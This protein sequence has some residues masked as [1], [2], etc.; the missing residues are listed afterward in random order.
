MKGTSTGKWADIMCCD[1][2]AGQVLGVAAIADEAPDGG[3]RVHTVKSPRGPVAENIA[4][5]VAEA[6]EVLAL[7]ATPDVATPDM[8][9]ALRGGREIEFR[10]E[11]NAGLRVAAPDAHTSRATGYQDAWCCTRNV[12]RIVCRNI[13]R[14]RL[15]M[16][17]NS[18]NAAMHK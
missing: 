17:S 4:T 5:F 1:M 2:T 6:Q 12:T 15:I 11:H 8:H 7:Q 13:M 10:N 16:T 9:A 3:V 18:Q 14:K